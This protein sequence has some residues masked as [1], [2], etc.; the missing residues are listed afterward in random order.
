ME[1]GKLPKES[2]QALEQKKKELLNN[3][4]STNIY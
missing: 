3:P 4:V 1:K 2:R